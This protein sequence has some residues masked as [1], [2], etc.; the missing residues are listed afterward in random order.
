MPAAVLLRPPLAHRERVNVS[1]DR[2]E[3]PIGDVLDGLGVTAAI[4]PD[5][6]VSGAIVLL[7]TVL[8]D[9]TVRLSVCH[10]EG[11]S[12]IERAGMVRLADA[13]EIGRA[14]NGI[15]PGA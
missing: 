9:G 11:L 4:E 6:L 13:M 3:K 15:E 7:K 8:P 2:E 5:A 1:G 12:W 10:S 14:V